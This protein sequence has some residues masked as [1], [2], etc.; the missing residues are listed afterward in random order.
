VK[1][2]SP[3]GSTDIKNLKTPVLGEHRAIYGQQKKSI[4]QAVTFGYYVTTTRIR[5]KTS[6]FK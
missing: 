3:K 2:F 5:I 1:S 6:F 4:R